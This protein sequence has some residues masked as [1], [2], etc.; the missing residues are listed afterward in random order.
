MISLFNSNKF[1]STSIHWVYLCAQHF[2]SRS[3]GHEGPSSTVLVLQNP[4][5]TEQEA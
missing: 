4:Y 2:T 5:S 3:G 1:N